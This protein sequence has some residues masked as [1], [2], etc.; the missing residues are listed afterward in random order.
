M[1]IEQI[2]DVP[3]NGQL[4]IQLPSSLKN[5]KR[6]KLIIDEIDEALENKI[7]LLNKASQ[8]KDFLSDLEEVNN[9]FEF[10]EKDIEE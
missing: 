9:D 8:D 4:V 2:I 5:K 7:A 10:I 3:A 6:V 1:S